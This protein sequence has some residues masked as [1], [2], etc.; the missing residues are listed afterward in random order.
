MLECPAFAAHRE[1]MFRGLREL[2]PN[3]VINNNNRILHTIVHGIATET[4][5]LNKNIF[6]IVYTFIADSRRFSQI[7]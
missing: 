4:I 6:S 2:L 5:T 3:T 7:D 1:E